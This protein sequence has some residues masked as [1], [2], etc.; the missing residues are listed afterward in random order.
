VRVRLTTD[1]TEE[2]KI[3]IWSMAW[4]NYRADRGVAFGG[5]AFFLDSAGGANGI[6]RAQGRDSFDIYISPTAAETPQWRGLLGD[7]GAFDPAHDDVNDIR[8][9]FRLL[10]LESSG[11]NSRIDEGTV[12]IESIQIDRIAID[13]I[14]SAGEVFAPPISSATHAPFVFGEAP[15]S[16]AID[17]GAKVAR[18][19][20]GLNDKATLIP[21]MQSLSGLERIYPVEWES[22]TLYRVSARVQSGAGSSESDPVDRIGLFADTA[23]NEVIQ[24]S[25][26]LRGAEGMLDRAGSPR[27]P[28]EAGG[29][30][31]YSMFFFSQNATVSPLEH[32]NRLRGFM[33]LTNRAS[34]YG[35]G[36]GSDP[37]EA[38]E[39]KVER[40]VA[41]PG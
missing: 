39:L 32:D 13:A 40:M 37:V 23:T 27:L 31:T 29:A 10:D 6:G 41:P 38:I 8:L 15:L 11:N 16:A 24:N 36:A 5:E 3:P 19:A 20:L 1:Q 30:Q 12:C 9:V 21:H 2:L 22:E 28:E 35:E 25:Y 26:V 17:E 14:E 7:G 33:D 34:L 4:D 18:Y